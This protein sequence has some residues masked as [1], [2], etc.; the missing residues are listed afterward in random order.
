MYLF[1]VVSDLADTMESLQTIAEQCLPET[2]ESEAQLV[3]DNISQDSCGN[4][5]INSLYKCQFCEEIFKGIYSFN[6]DYFYMEFVHKLG[7]K[8]C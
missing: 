7:E 8:N 6:A 4:L 1:V 5:A 3:A 2:W